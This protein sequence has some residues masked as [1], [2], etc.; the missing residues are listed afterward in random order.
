MGHF[1]WLVL[2]CF[3]LIFIKIKE[4]TKKLELAHFKFTARNQKPTALKTQEKTCSRHTQE[5]KDQQKAEK[6]KDARKAKI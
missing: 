3:V 1:F 2:M 5:K 4:F 6:R